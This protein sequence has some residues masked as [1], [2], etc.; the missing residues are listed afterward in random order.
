MSVPDYPELSVK[1]MYSTLKNDETVS[2]FIPDYGDKLLP[3]KEFFHKLIWT[4]YPA[5]MYDIISQAH[6]NRG[7]EQA[8]NDGELV[9]IC[10]AIAKEIEDVVL[11][12]SKLTDL[13]SFHYSQTWKDNSFVEEKGQGCKEEKSSKETCCEFSIY[14]RCRVSI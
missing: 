4:L 3:D 10:E 9:E 2:Q 8:D 11:L 13:I 1:N 6:K 7:V 14:H 12:P 5:E